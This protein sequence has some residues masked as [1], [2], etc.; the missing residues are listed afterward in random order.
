MA[1]ISTIRQRNVAFLLIATFVLSSCAGAQRIDYAAQFAN[2]GVKFTQTLPHF[3]EE[4]YRLAIDADSATLVTTR[5]EPGIT[6]KQLSERL[7]QAD[8]DLERKSALIRSL[9]EHAV[10]LGEYFQE[11]QKLTDEDVGSGVGESTAALVNGIVMASGDLAAEIPF[12]V[13]VDKIA[14]PAGN[15]VVV[16]LKNHALKREL[17]DHGETIDRELAVQEA[18]LNKLGRNMA[19]DSEAWTT[20]AFVNP[21]YEQYR[22]KKEPLGWRWYKKRR[23]YLTAKQVIESAQQAEEAMKEMRKAWRELALGGPDGSTVARLVRH[24]QATIALVDAL[25]T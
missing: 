18:I 7:R 6:S 24:V 4:Y 16:S 20:V 15:F 1:I 10:L 13:P 5:G 23:T 14:R 9:K 8:E 19:R 12:G 11:I 3:Y 22:D 21:V 2:Q 25:K 17:E